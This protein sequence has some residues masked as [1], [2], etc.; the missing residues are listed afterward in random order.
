M[1]Y[2]DHNA[3]SPLRPEARAAMLQALEEAGN[4]SSVHAA[5][6]KARARVDRARDQIAALV[7]APS[8]SVVLTSGGSE[9]NAMALRGAVAAALAAEERITRIFV[10]TIEHD[11]AISPSVFIRSTAGSRSR[12][13]LISRP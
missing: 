1:T 11:S 13:T 4:A 10:S 5:G 9:A 3:N 7:R 8:A 6:R 12:S 2:L